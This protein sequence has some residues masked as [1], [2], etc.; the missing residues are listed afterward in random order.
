[1]QLDRLQLQLRQ[2]TTWEAIDL[3]F[4]VT[5]RYFKEIFLPW[6]IL[7]TILF[8]MSLIICF[9]GF[10][11]LGTLFFWYLLPLCERIVLFV[12]SRAV[13]D[14]K[15]H[16]KQSLK[17]WW[18]ECKKGFWANMFFW[19]FTPG[20]SFLL[21]IW[22]LEGL[23]GQAFT[24]R[25]S[26]LNRRVGNTATWLGVVYVHVEALIYYSAFMLILFFIPENTLINYFENF[27]PDS[28]TNSF[29]GLGFQIMG[30][31]FYYIAILFLRP[32]YVS[33]GF[34]LYLNRRIDLEGWDIEV[35]FR[36]LAERLT[37][38]TSK[39]LSFLLITLTLLSP[40]NLNGD[41]SLNTPPV[42]TLEENKAAIKSPSSKAQK[43]L[44]DVMSHKDFNTK[45]TQEHWFKFDEKKK[46]EKE[47][48]LNTNTDFSAIAWIIK[49]ISILAI[50]VL[51]GYF[52]YLFAKNLNNAPASIPQS[53]PKTK[54]KSIMGMDMTDSELKA[55]ILDDIQKLWQDGEHR[56]A[57]SLL[58]RSS[59]H[60]LLHKHHLPL[61]ESD[62]ENDCLQRTHE[63]CPEKTQN[64]F[65]ALT[66]HWLLLA[67]AEQIPTEQVFN[68][69]C[70]NW[71]DSMTVTTL[72]KEEA[73]V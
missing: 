26:I 58:Y 25:K 68:E 21:P 32:F 17:A 24:K 36:S 70:Q 20:R 42:P 5:Q 43:D 4:S 8:I 19:R 57:L 39:A 12:V 29:E 65:Q 44:N 28:L 45:V 67:Y 27:D 1:M 22:Q 50:L 14:E 2:R 61:K 72:Q 69:L 18:P 47:S 11:F 71:Q 60:R 13:F 23:K 73:T 52:V 51:L 37:K 7:V 30:L 63:H 54:P 49:L 6:S 40:L 15:L 59:I 62:T 31:S 33:A 3:G 38:S 56:Q 66:Q 46:E 41:E 53:M 64:Y 34:M 35:K 55:N 16:Y 48:E 9:A 10:P